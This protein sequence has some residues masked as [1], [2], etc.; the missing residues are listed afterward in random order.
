MKQ[1]FKMLAFIIFGAAIVSGFAS[2]QN[3]NIPP[4]MI[5]QYQRQFNNADNAPAP[6]QDEVSPPDDQGSVVQTQ[7]KQSPLRK[8][9]L[10]AGEKDQIVT[11]EVSPDQKMQS[12][13]R[14]EQGMVPLR[15]GNN[16]LSVQAS[17]RSFY[18]AVIAMIIFAFF[19]FE[20]WRRLLK[21]KSKPTLPAED[22]GTVC[23]TCG[24]SG[25]VTHK[26]K[27]TVDCGSCKKTGRELCKYCNG[28]GRYGG[29]LTVPETE[30]DLQ[31]YMKC[32]YCGGTGFAE[33]PVPCSICKGN[34]KIE[35]EESY[36][37]KCSACKGSGR[38]TK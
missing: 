29:G 7:E 28:T 9:D 27:K 25:N 26:R 35:I 20:W 19:G 22:D 18:F 30:E 38:I 23:K 3:E 11:S 37:E 1:R 15:K 2:A 33:I 4:E 34:K 8:N 6:V 31:N 36:E 12:E 24:G 17:D 14:A 16:S 21:K 5:R 13:N 32:D 10:P